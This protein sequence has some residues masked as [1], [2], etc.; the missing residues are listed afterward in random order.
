MNNEQKYGGK[1][2]PLPSKF[3]IEFF[4]AYELA[5]ERGFIDF[6]FQSKSQAMNFRFR[7]YSFR[8]S[9][10]KLY[11]VDSEADKLFY[12]RVDLFEIRT[13]PPLTPQDPWTIQLASPSDRPTAEVKIMRETFKKL[14]EEGEGSIHL[15]ID[16]V[17]S[18]D[19][20]RQILSAEEREKQEV[21][22]P[23]DFKLVPDGD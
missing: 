4:Q 3:P 12:R 11:R 17:P 8:S 7:L 22:S 21:P 13:I 5:G 9:I 19:A 18:D 16:P 20:F 14:Q 15:H 1:N 2:L 10:R 23:S 6:N